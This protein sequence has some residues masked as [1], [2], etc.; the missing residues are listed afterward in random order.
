M[1]PPKFG[2]IFR[3]FAGPG[4]VP[5]LHPCPATLFSRVVGIWALL[6]LC[7]AFWRGRCPAPAP[8]MR[9]RARPPGHAIGHICPSGGW[10]MPAALGAS[11]RARPC[12]LAFRTS[13]AVLGRILAYPDNCRDMP[14]FQALARLMTTP[15]R[16]IVHSPVFPAADVEVTG[17]A[18]PGTLPRRLPWRSGQTGPRTPG[19]SPG[20]VRRSNAGFPASSWRT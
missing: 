13:H 10:G 17:T 16:L 12:T 14:T 8:E 11:A 6:A 20:I 3:E 4:D 18:S 9:R 7:G 5:P 2:A 19:C 1:Y 15:G